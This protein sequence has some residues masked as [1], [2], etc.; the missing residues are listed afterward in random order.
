M[1]DKIIHLSLKYRLFI[2]SVA[3]I[4]VVYGIMTA[5]HLPVDVLPDL[6]RPMVTVMTEALNLAPEEVETQVT[7]PLERSLSGV[8]GLVRLRTVSGIGLSIIFLEF[9]WNSDVYRQRQ[10]V[11]E[12]LATITSELPAN[13]IPI[14]TPISS[15]MGEIMLLEYL[16][17]K[18][19]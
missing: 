15:I 4:L 16:L 11:S 18:Q 3:T 14:M 12:R 17:K 6:N 8:P 1:F 7:I 5:R 9:D 13:T 2:I 10:L 19:K